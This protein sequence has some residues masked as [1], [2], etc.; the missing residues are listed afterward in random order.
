MTDT[1]SRGDVAEFQIAAANEDG[2]FTRV[3][4]KSGVLRKG[5][6]F[7]ARTRPRRTSS[8][9]TRSQV[10]VMWPPYGSRRHATG[11][12][13]ACGR[14]RSRD[15]LI[16]ARYWLGIVQSFGTIWIQVWP[17]ESRTDSPAALV[18]VKTSKMSGRDHVTS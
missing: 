13:D 3:Q 18:S 5:C 10:V 14:R 8:Q 11:S 6:A 7:I 2:T 9:S 17:G 12:V 1:T 15:R 16:E 4:R